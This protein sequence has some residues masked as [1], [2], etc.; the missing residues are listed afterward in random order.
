MTD[1]EKL[2]DFLWEKVECSGHYSYGEFDLQEL[3]QLREL[4]SA[5]LI[6]RLCEYSPTMF[7]D[8]FPERKKL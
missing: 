2:E 8:V 6:E 7:T 1:N 3:R 5:A 4:V